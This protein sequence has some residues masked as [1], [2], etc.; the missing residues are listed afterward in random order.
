MNKQLDKDILAVVATVSTEQWDHLA[1]LVDAVD[2]RDYGAWV[3]GNVTGHTEAGAPI[4]SMPF[5]YWSEALNQLVD[6]LYEYNLVYPF[7]WMEWSDATRWGDSDVPIAEQTVPDLIKFTTAVLRADRF[8]EGTLSRAIR[9]SDF[10]GRLTSII[11][12]SRPHSKAT[13]PQ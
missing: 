8:A 10:L 5:F 13:P 1:T 7:D 9:E 3:G 11:T 4:I 2:P 6:T 12:Q